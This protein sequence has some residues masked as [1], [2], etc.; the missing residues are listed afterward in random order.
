MKPGDLYNPYKT[1]V[2]L[3]IP[4]A[5]AKYRDL[6]PGAKICLG[7]LH[8]Y[9]GENGK[10][11]PSHET[12]AAEIGVK[13]RMV[14]NYIK[15]LKEKS[16]IKVV[17]SQTSN[18]YYFI[19]HDILEDSLRVNNSTRQ[20][21]ATPAGKELPPQPARDC[22]GRE[23]LSESGKENGALTILTE[24]DKNKAVE[25]IIAHYADLFAKAYGTSPV[26]TK[27]NRQTLARLV[28]QHSADLLMAA[29]EIH[30]KEPDSWTK[31][32]GCLLATLEHNLPGYIEKL[33]RRKAEDEAER[34]R[35]EYDR[36]QQE[37]WKA[38]EEEAEK[39]R[40]AWE[41][42]PEEEKQRQREEQKRAIEEI[43]QAKQ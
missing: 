43:K 12:L 1:F 42:L 31:E 24:K 37:T 38:Q 4:N 14:R 41:A 17:H 9:A 34:K 21:I 26:I 29:V 8:Q 36:Q 33:N 28:D 20:D 40:A 22:Q 6:S 23:S 11:F 13:E 19:W 5:I 25:N 2:G 16:F 32:R 18:H 35:K 7:R 15:E 30:V 27:A 3:F 39:R 10:A